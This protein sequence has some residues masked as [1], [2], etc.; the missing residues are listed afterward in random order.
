MIPQLR[1]QLSNDFWKG[2]YMV[3]IL[4]G[5]IFT[6]L[7]VAI[8]RNTFI[9]LGFLLIIILIVGLLAFILNKKHYKKTYNLKSNFFP[10]IQNFMSWGLISCYLF[11]A[12]NF[13]FA[14]KT[15]TDHTFN[16]ISKSSLPAYRSIET[17]LPTV[18]FK[19]NDYDKELVLYS[20]DSGIVGKAEKVT[21]QIRKGALGFDIIDKYLLVSSK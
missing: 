16:I 15:I 9:H 7:A 4:I 8:F 12:T 10:L 18:R 20:S 11:L 2:F 17:R 13:Y 6:Y 1:R 3:S 21:V 19:Y 14:N 5:L